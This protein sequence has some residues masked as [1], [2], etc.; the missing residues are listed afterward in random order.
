MRHLP[1]CVVAL[2][3]VAGIVYGSDRE[4]TAIP[5]IG[6][7]IGDFSLPRAA[8]G[9]KWSL[10]ENGRNARAVVV[11]FLG[12]ECPVSNSYAPTLAALHRVYSPKGVVFVGVNSNQQD[13]VAEVA[14]HAKEYAL[15]FPVLK[16]NR[17]TLGDRLR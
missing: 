16:D 2:I 5:P 8:D 9:Q 11:L 12:T 4:A 14:R 1:L 15:P 13:D 10:A 17:S 7:R 6:T 3:S